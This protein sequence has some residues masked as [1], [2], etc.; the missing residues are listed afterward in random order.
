MALYI[1]TMWHWRRLI[2]FQLNKKHCL[3]CSFHENKPRQLSKSDIR[4]KIRGKKNNDQKIKLSLFLDVAEKQTDWPRSSFQNPPPCKQHVPHVHLGCFFFF[5][6]QIFGVSVCV[7]VFVYT[8]KCLRVH[9]VKTEAAPGCPAYT[10]TILSLNHLTVPSTIIPAPS[11]LFIWCVFWLK[12]ETHW[13]RRLKIKTK[14]YPERMHKHWK[15]K[16]LLTE[17]GIH[18]EN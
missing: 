3:V 15:S 16:L 18:E 13:E 14:G 5:F 2:F 17:L 10:Q 11:M 4:R 1:C 12:W 7:C 9:V 8:C 6:F